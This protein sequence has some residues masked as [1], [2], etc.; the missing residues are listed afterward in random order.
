MSIHFLSRTGIE[1]E[2]NV[3]VGFFLGLASAMGFSGSYVL[4][5]LR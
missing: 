2:V 5:F 4:F 1:T 3:T